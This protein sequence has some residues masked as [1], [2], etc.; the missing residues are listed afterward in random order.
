MGE[1]KTTKV[2]DGSE[3]RL[4]V[5]RPS[6][7]PK[8]AIIVFQEIFGV[9]SHIRDVADR[10]A[11]LGYLA[12][13]P[14]LFHRQIVGFESDY[15]DTA[16]PFELMKNYSSAEMAEDINESYNWLKNELGS[17]NIATI[18]YCMGG[19]VSFLANALVPLKAAISYYGPIPKIIEQAKNQHG[20]LLMFW[21]GKDEHLGREAPHK[22][23]EALDKAGK[24][25]TNAIFSEADHGFNCDQRESYN[26]PASKQS[27]VLVEEFL[28]ENVKL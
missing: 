24:I 13:A 23:A 14:D 7:Q 8:A 17:D 10:F 25:Y 16:K 1:W 18:G 20:P 4:Y 26:E 12:I 27:W 6:E 3:I 28:A 5:A 21:G 2:N 15:K 11:K 22:S 9:N 19:M